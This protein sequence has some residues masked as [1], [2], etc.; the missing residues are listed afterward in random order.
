[1]LCH[2]FLN[3]GFVMAFLAAAERQ[4]KLGVS[5]NLLFPWVVYVRQIQTFRSFYDGCETGKS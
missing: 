4:T 3:E 2:D 1:M 5:M